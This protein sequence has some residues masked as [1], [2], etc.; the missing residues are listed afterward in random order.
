M[1]KTITAAI[2]TAVSCAVLSLGT[3]AASETITYDFG[4]GSEL[5]KHVKTKNGFHQ[6]LYD[7]MLSLTCTLGHPVSY[8]IE[9]L[10]LEGYSYISFALAC[11]HID[12]NSTLE[13][14][15]TTE[16]GKEYRSIID[17]RD[18]SLSTYIARLPE[19]D[20]AITSCE[21]FVN[22]ILGGDQMYYVDLDFV[23]FHKTKDLMLL[24]IG[25]DA[26]MNGE[27]KTPDSPAVIKDGY[28]LTPARFV[29][30]SF[31]ANVEWIEAERKVIITND[32]VKIELIIDSTAAFINGKPTELSVPACIIDGRTFTPARFVA[33]NLG[34]NVDWEAHTKTVIIEK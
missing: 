12:E 9:D 20:E 29:A 31:G 6:E 32:S 18:T 34:A 21:I 1:K 11:E 22:S 16:S 5:E 15:C 30:E 3:L 7:G 8:V 2:C 25:S 4:V 19:T 33:E 26:V 24:T 23:K 13:I 28:T 10:H 14:I 17:Y 27:V